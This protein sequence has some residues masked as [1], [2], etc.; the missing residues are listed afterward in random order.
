M[1]DAYIIRGGQPLVGEVRLS[2]AKN[3][4]LKIII[5]S[6]LFEKTTTIINVPH[7]SD[8][9]DLLHLINFLGGTARFIAK[10][11]VFVDGSGI[12]K[13]TINFLYASKT[14]VS[15]MFFAPL[16]YRLGRANI[17]NP[18]GCR[19]GSRPI[20][21]SIVFMKA[22]GINIV[23]NEDDGYYK[24]KMEKRVKGINF[25]FTKPTHTG[26]ELAMLFAILAEGESRIE[27]VCQEPEI[28]DLISFLNLAG[29]KISFKQ[30]AIYIQGVKRLGTVERFKIASD[31]NEAITFALFAL[32]TKG[33]ILLGPID[34]SIIKAFTN[35]LEKVGAGVN[36][37]DKTIRFF[38]KKS[39]SGLDIITARYP[40]FMTDWQAPWAVL[41]TQAD[42]VSII[43]ETVFE[44][45]FSYIQELKRLGAQIEYFQPMVDEPEKLY[46]FNLDSSAK[47]T[48]HAIK[49][50]GKTEL[51]NGVLH[52]S[53]LRA[54]ASLLIAAAVAHGES[55]VRG[56]S[57]IN[58]GYEAID[59]KLRQ[60]S[61]IIKKV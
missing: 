52:V 22:L 40:G 1:E 16:L 25:R 46:Q 7:I 54:G 60:L 31:R 29:A 6:L 20:D 17:P 9:E 15:F 61:A 27:N 24:A 59:K 37:Q 5:A 35:A 36:C 12:K 33:S 48:P 50:F 43:H 28:D 3:A 32:A 21:R 2:G 30:D 55:V 56:A 14:R 23:Y 41:M 53:D 44:N 42:G 38:Y 58:R 47:N 34:R 57:V 19:I 8:I 49:I 4:A 26:T 11:E 45:R 18:G 13:D 39:F 51:H 10:N